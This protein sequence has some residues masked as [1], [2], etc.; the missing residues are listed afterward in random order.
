MY[1][2]VFNCSCWLKRR[3]SGR[4]GHSFDLICGG[5]GGVSNPPKTPTRPDEGGTNT[6]CS[7]KMTAQPEPPGSALFGCGKIFLYVM[8]WTLPHNKS[9][10]PPKHTHT[11]SKYKH[12]SLWTLLSYRLSARTWSIFN[13][14]SVASA[15]HLTSTSLRLTST[16]L[17]M[18]LL[19]IQRTAEMH[20]GFSENLIW[21]TETASVMFLFLVAD[22]KF[23]R[24]TVICVC[25]QK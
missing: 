5:L 18:E 25:I 15:L 13:L 14:L 9:Q 11:S 23:I 3:R 19:M 20:V 12:G 10:P 2:F 1:H 24:L 16:S 7:I 22:F 21:C 6:N 17:H 4:T 8:T